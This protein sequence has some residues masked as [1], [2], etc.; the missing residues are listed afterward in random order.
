MHLQ[1][2]KISC[3]VDVTFHRSH[4]YPILS[5]GSPSIS[6]GYTMSTSQV[7]HFFHFFAFFLRTVLKCPVRGACFCLSEGPLEHIDVGHH[8]LVGAGDPLLALAPEVRSRVRIPSP[9]VEAIS[10]MAFD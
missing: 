3:Q 8:L 7:S 6:A 4:E 10:S 1:P 5:D 9:F 2:T